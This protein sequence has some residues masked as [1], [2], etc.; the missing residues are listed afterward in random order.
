[1][2]LRLLSSVM[3]DEETY[4]RRVGFWLRMARER[5]NITQEAAATSLGL[6]GKSKSTVSAW[7]NGRIPKL[8]MLRRLAA[9]YRVPLK[10]FTEPD[11][12]PEERLDQIVRAAGALEREDWESAGDQGPA[13]DDEPDDGLRTRSA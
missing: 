12:T 10:T 4:G 11:V 5:A 2:P 6:S 3:E 1:M 7:E 13:T 8:A 9:L